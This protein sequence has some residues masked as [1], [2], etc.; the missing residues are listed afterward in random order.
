L[1]DY[2]WLVSDDAKTYLEDAAEHNGSLVRV[3]LG[4]RKQLGAARTHLVIAQTELRRRASVKFGHASRMFFTRQ[5]L[6]QAT[7]EQIAGYKAS[8]LAE[9]ESVVDLC[10]GIGGDLLGL[11]RRGPAAAVDKDP[12]ALLLAEA[13]CKAN[14]LRVDPF[15]EAD[16]SDWD[17]RRSQ[18]WH[19]DPDR[20]PGGS[21]TTRTESQDPDSAAIDQ[22]LSANP[23]G[24][25]KL[26][27]AA[28]AQENWTQRAERE[29]IGNRRECRQQLLWFDTLARYPGQHVA[30]VFTSEGSPHAVYGSPSNPAE[31]ASH[32][33]RYVFEPH[34]AV[35]AARLAGQLSDRYKLP[36]V[37]PSIPYL[38]GDQEVHDPAMSCFEILEEVPLDM[39]YIRQAVR[40][41]GIG[42]LEVKKRGVRVDPEDLRRQIHPRGEASGTLIVLPVRKQ[43]VALLSR[44][45]LSP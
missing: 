7:D 42:N 32:L 45:V 37:S 25:V 18:A 41:R 24:V 33:G 13:N 8:R 9:G 36:C 29:W 6:E 16:A 3:T 21:R 34:A 23:N 11:A 28:R 20:R 39:K 19:L 5:L 27:P 26:A 10:C 35:L 12:L 31:V 40:S 15:C 44:R 1:D 2:R 14:G 30:T 43:P 4:L 17:V 38:T 22:L